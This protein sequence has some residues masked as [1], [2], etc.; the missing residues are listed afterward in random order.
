MVELTR[1]PSRGFA[2]ALILV[3]RPA[4]MLVQEGEV[5][6]EWSAA[7]QDLSSRSGYVCVW[8]VLCWHLML[9]GSEDAQSKLYRVA[10]S[11]W[12][13]LRCGKSEAC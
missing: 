10:M 13:N 9:V 6:L 5:W 12:S 1:G 3:M 11:E 4:R 8:V 2:A 7:H